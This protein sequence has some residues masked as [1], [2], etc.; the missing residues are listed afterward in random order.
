MSFIAVYTTFPNIVEANFISSKLLEKK[1]IACYNTF[2]VKNSYHWL[3][4]IETGEEI[5]S[6]MK[7]R[8]DNW[9]V[10]KQ[11][12]ESWHNYQT[13]CIMRFEVE[14][15]DDFEKW[16]KEETKNYSIT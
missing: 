15:N 2:P 8:K 6:L 13:P 4:M 16:I 7:T 12:I 1:I 14:A 5:V 10:L 3:G 9:K 11:K